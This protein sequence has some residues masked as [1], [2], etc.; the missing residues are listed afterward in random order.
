MKSSEFVF[1]YVYLM[2]YKC[3]EINLNRGGSNKYSPD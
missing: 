2:Y 1:D 3:H